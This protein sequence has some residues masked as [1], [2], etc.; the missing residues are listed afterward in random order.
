MLMAKS[1][2][3]S[4]Q[5]VGLFPPFGSPKVSEIPDD[6]GIS[7]GRN[8]VARRTKTIALRSTGRRTYRAWNRPSCGVPAGPHFRRWATPSWLFFQPYG[9]TPRR[10]LDPDGGIPD[11]LAQGNGI[12]NGTRQAGA[13]DCACPSAP[14]RWTT[15]VG[16]ANATPT[17]S[18]RAMISIINACFA[19]TCAA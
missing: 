16:K 2:R 5:A 19:S 18:A 10:T 7:V 9:A 1:K 15:R 8:P 4:I 17:S 12:T 6:T 3:A 13:A 11:K 14:A